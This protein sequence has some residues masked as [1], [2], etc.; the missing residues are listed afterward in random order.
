MRVTAALVGLLACGVVSAAPNCDRNKDDD[1]I[2]LACNIYW[3]ARTENY[4]GMLAVAVVTLNRVDAFGF[5]NTVRE[6]VWSRRQFSWTHDGLYDT[7]RNRRAWKQAMAI[8]ERFTI[9]KAHRSEI[10]DHIPNRIMAEI[11]GRP[12]PDPDC[13]PYRNLVNI[14]V[15]LAQEVDP[16][17]GALFYHADYIKTPYWADARYVTVVIKRHVFYARA[18]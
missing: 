9:T 12:D 4:E 17:D 6:V 3:E 11:L 13:T 7:P 2:A 18:L 16:T 15:Y 1:R 8:A 5:A 10:C 14:H